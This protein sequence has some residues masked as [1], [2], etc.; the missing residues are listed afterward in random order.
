MPGLGGLAQGAGAAATQ[1][2]LNAETRDQ[3]GRT[4]ATLTVRVSG[5]EGVPA[6][7]AIVVR[8]RGQQIAGAALDADG[9]TQLTLD[10]PAGDHLL[11][12]AYAG[13]ETH[14]ASVSK[15]ASVRAMDTATPDFGITVAPASLTLTAGQSGTV[16]A[17]V[18][19]VNAAALTAPMFVTL[20]CSDNP[21][22]SSCSF[23]P[24]NIEILPTTT[25]AVTSTM[26]VTTQAESGMARPL[27]RGGASPVAWAVLFPGVLALG[28]LAW[29]VR[30]GTL[31]RLVLLGLVA[32]VTLASATGC[33]SRYGYKNHPPPKNPATPAGSYS[34]KVTAQ[35]SNGV[36]A[37]THYTTLALTVK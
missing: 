36:V 31:S 32:L 19:P 24:Q 6:T 22:Q 7:G 27:E 21:D 9:K 26:V 35:S 30:R 28:G 14:R 2:T 16:I 4:R 25:S 1:T 8:D 18:T 34:L 33:N 17:S 3:D 37:T 12:A 10:L 29:G 20:S 13:D 23:T 11:R 15:P 5:E